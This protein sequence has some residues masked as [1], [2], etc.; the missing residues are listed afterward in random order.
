M[1]QF[2]PP[3][4]PSLQSLVIR[5]FPTPEGPALEVTENPVFR[6]LGTMFSDR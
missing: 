5:K 1:R 3:D 6:G 4:Q 2:T